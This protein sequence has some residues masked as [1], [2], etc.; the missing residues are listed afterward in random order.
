MDFVKINVVDALIGI[1]IEGLDLE[2]HDFG[3]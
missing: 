3:A 2:E 1:S